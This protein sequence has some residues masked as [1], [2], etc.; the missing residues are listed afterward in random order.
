[1]PVQ[2]AVDLENCSHDRWGT[3]TQMKWDVLSAVH[4]IAGAQRLITCTTIK[5]SFVKCGFTDDHVSSNDDS[6]VK[7][8]EEEEN[9]LQHLEVQF[10]DCTTC[11]SGLEVCGIMNV[12]HLTMPEEE[13]EGKRK[14]QNIKPC[15]LIQVRN[16]K[17]P[18][19]TC[20]NLILR[21]ILL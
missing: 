10:E 18:P 5:N 15:S 11:D 4:F 3:A 21:S 14:L 2:K 19:S 20:V 17:Q 9:D 7:L 13:P 16:W 6:A 1:V 12:A 8:S